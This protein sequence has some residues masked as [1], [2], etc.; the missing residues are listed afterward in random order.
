MNLHFILLFVIF[1]VSFEFT[2]LLRNTNTIEFPIILVVLNN[3]WEELLNIFNNLL[4]FVFN[5]T[6]K[7]WLQV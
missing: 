5:F 6:E 4:K 7:L 2:C 1:E 3:Y